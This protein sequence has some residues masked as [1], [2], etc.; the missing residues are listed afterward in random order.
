M[1]DPSPLI[2]IVDDNAENLQFLGSLLMENGYDVG[3]GN[4]R[5]P[6]PDL[7]Q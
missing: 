5:H 3:G 2:L 6:G 4:E 1:T 7:L